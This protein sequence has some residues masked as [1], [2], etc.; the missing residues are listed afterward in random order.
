MVLSSMVTFDTANLE[1]VRIF[2]KSLAAT[3][4]RH[5]IIITYYDI[6]LGII[7]K[8]HD[9]KYCIIDIVLVG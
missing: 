9:G 8:Y 6:I 2:F 1:T 3:K 5:D 7:E 4:T